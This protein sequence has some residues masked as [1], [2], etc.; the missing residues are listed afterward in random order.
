MKTFYVYILT[1]F[2]KTVLYIGVTNDLER[3][4]WEHQTHQ[5]KGSFTDRYN[6]TNL[7][8]FEEYLNADTAIAREKELKDWSRERKEALI[9]SKNPE[10]K[11]ISLSRP[12]KMTY[13]QEVQMVLEEIYIENPELRPQ[14]K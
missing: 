1:N 11:T 4:L 9:N 12:K 14:N 3:R 10:W 7:I 2:K 13:Q 6:V 5:N 8:Y